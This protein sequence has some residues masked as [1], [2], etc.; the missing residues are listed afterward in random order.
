MP[1]LTAV[2]LQ[3]FQNLFSQGG[4]YPSPLELPMVYVILCEVPSNYIHVYI[5]VSINVMCLLNT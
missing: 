3:D 5:R 4:P 2:F 1:I